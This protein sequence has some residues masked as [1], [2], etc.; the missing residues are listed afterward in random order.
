MIDNIKYIGFYNRNDNPNNFK[1]FPA[2]NTKINYI[3]SALKKANYSVDILALGET[4]SKNKFFKAKKTVI[5]SNETVNYVSTFSSN[6]LI[7]KLLSR[8]YLS[9]QVLFFLLFKVKKGSTVILY[10]SYPLLKI[11]KLSR[12]LKEY[13]LILELE[14]IYQAA[15]KASSKKIEN[16][17][18]YVRQ[19]DGYIYVNDI[20][21]NKCGIHNKPFVVCYGNYKIEKENSQKIYDE[22]INVVYAG[23]LADYDSDVYLAI[24]S[25][26]L[27]PDNYVL[28]ILGYGIEKHVDNLLVKIQEI[29]NK[30]DME[31][32]IFHGKMIGDDYINFLSKCH[33][34]LSTRVLEDQY[35]DFTFPSKVL[36]YLGNRLATVSSPIKCI[37]KSKV[38][39]YIYFCKDI[40]PASVA[41]T[42]QE[43]DFTKF[44]KDEQIDML[45][46]LDNDF[47]KN[48]KYLIE[49]IK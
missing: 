38:A 1:S 39:K 24:N 41:S 36:V 7:L 40:S 20:I 8:I 4:T 23:V 3:I 13:T 12:Y 9:L 32:I 30:M 34:G 45:V 43:I 31:K 22:V 47:V 10:H 33:I 49:N 5:D 17:M 35:S 46:T 27:L 18:K 25:A 37:L 15:W 42:I 6:F 48:L 44:K 28:H 21:G 19:A 14:E 29:N 11:V 16:E 26:K 2:S